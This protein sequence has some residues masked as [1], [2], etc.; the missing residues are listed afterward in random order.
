MEEGTLDDAGCKP[1]GAGTGTDPYRIET[2]EAFAWFALEHPQAHAVLVADIDLTAQSGTEA[3]RPADTAWPGD[4]VLSGTLDGDGH[5]LLFA[6]EGA[7]LFAQVA[8]TGTAKWLVLGRTD[9]Q[10]REA[11][12][13][14][15]RETLVASKQTLAGSVAGANEGT[16]RGIVNLMAVGI[17]GGEGAAAGEALAGGIVALND[18]RIIDCANLGAV[19]NA[20]T[21]GSSAAAGIA[22]A[23]AGSV[24]A[25]YNAA[26]VNA[27]QNGAPLTAST[28]LDAA[29]CYAADGE[30]SEHGALSMSEL[31]GAA[32]RLNAG[33]ADA[34]AVW[35]AGGDATRGLPVPA[36]SAAARAGEPDAS[37]QSQ[38][39]DTTPSGAPEANLVSKTVE[40]DP[41]DENGQVVQRKEIAAW[42]V[43]DQDAYEYSIYVTDAL[44]GS[45][46]ELTLASTDP[47]ANMTAE[48]AAEA[49]LPKQLL[50]ALNEETPEETPAANEGESE[51]AP[52]EA[53]DPVADDA[54]SESADA[55]ANEST[56]I[57]TARPNAADAAAPALTETVDVTWTSDDYDQA[58]V[59]SSGAT[60]TAQ[61]STGYQLAEGAIPLSIRI[62]AGEASTLATSYYSWYSVGEVIANAAN[63]AGYDRSSDVTVTIDKTT[64][65]TNSVVV[66]A[67]NESAGGFVIETPEQLAWFA[68]KTGDDPG[69]Y[70]ALNVTIKA[71]S[72]IDLAGTDYGGAVGTGP[73]G[74]FDEAD[75]KYNRALRWSLIGG[76]DSDPYKGTFTAYGAKITNLYV[77]YGSMQS[78]LFGWVDGA[79]IAGV[80]VAGGLVDD[81][82]AGGIVWSA[83][84]STLKDCRNAATVHSAGGFAGGI[85]GEVTGTSTIT[86]CSNEG[87]VESSFAAGGIVG[88]V[89]RMGASEIS[90][91]Y[92]SGTIGGSPE[93]GGG[94]YG[95]L[96]ANTG[97]SVKGCLSVGS[98]GG[99]GA[100]RAFGKNEGNVAISNSYCLDTSETDVAAAKKT[101]AQL[102][103]WGAA[104]A[105]NDGATG[106]D[107]ADPGNVAGMDAW[108][109][110]GANLP[111]LIARD[112]DG[113][114]TAAMP[115]AADWSD[116]G[117]WV[118]S[119][120]PTDAAGAK[121][122]P[123][124]VNDQFK[125]SSPEGLAWFSID[126]PKASS[127]INAG[128]D[129]DA[130]EIDLAGTKYGGSLADSADDAVK[131]ANALTWV[132][133]DATQTIAF[134]G[135]HVPVKNLHVD[136][137]ENAGLFGKIE[138]SSSSDFFGVDIASG[139]V[140]GT[141]TAAGLVGNL[142]AA[143]VLTCSNKATIEGAVSAGGLVGASNGWLHA[144]SSYNTGSIESPAGKA[145]GLDGSIGGEN[146][147]EYCYNAGEVSGHAATGALTATAGGSFVSS[148][149][150]SEKVA[151]SLVDVGASGLTAKA[152]AEF[153]TGEVAW[154]LDAY[155]D[156][157]GNTG[158]TWGQ[159]IVLK[160]DGS[161]DAAAG[162]A[163]PQFR[164]DEGTHPK[165]LK[166]T[167]TYDP[168]FGDVSDAS[169]FPTA[170]Y[171]NKGTSGDKT[172]GV[173]LPQAPAGATWVY[174]LTNASGGTIVSPYAPTLDADF[175]V[176]VEPGIS[177]WEDVGKKQ[178][179]DDL[180]KYHYDGSDWLF[181]PDHVEENSAA[182]E[183]NT[184]EGFI[185][186]KE[187][188]LAWFAYQV[189]QGTPGFAEANVTLRAPC[190]NEY[191]D[192]EGS[193][194]TSV[195]L[196]RGA[197]ETTI[198]EAKAKYEKA[199][200]WVP[201]G[202][203]TNPYKG[204][205][206]AYGLEI[207]TVYVDET[208]SASAGLFGYTDG[209][210]IRGVNLVTGYVESGLDTVS[211]GGAGG[212]V[213]VGTNI[214]MEDCRN[215]AAVFSA[216]TAGGLLGAAQ[217]KA[218][219]TR[220]SNKGLVQS[221][222]YAGGMFGRSDEAA[223]PNTTLYF[224]QNTGSLSGTADSTD[225]GGMYGDDHGA[226]IKNCLSLGGLSNGSLHALGLNSNSSDTVADSYYLDAIGGSG[227]LTDANAERSKTADQLQTWGAAYALNGGATGGTAGDGNVAGMNGW[228]WDGA[229]S[230]PALVMHDATGAAAGTMPKAADWPTVA[231][232]VDNF[233]PTDAAGTKLKP[234]GA[235]TTDDP[236]TISS[237]EGFAWFGVAVP[238]A[239]GD[240]FA[241]IDAST[242][243][244]DLAGL[245]YGGEL[246]DSADDAVKYANALKWVPV[247]SEYA[248]T[249]DG[250]GVPLANLHADERIFSSDGIGM[251]GSSSAGLFSELKDKSV[252]DGI[253]IASGYVNSGSYSAAGLVACSYYGVAAT[254]CSN[255]ATVVG[256]SAGGLVGETEDDP[257]R[258]AA[259]VFVRCSN[260]G[261]IRGQ[262]ASGGIAGVTGQES[263]GT[264]SAVDCY[265]EGELRSSSPGSS[266]G[267][268]AARV[269]NSATFFNCYNVGQTSGGA[270]L[271]V[272]AIGAIGFEGGSLSLA[273]C[274][275]DPAAV[276][277]TPDDAEHGLTAKSTAE[278]MSGEVAWLLD[279][280]GA[281]G[282][283]AA[284]PAVS[285][286]VWGQKVLRNATT[287][288]IEVP[289]P[290]VAY[291][292]DIYP[293]FWH[294]TAG[295]TADGT[296]VEDADHPRVARV[297]V[298]Y[299][300][301]AHDTEY[302]FGN[303]G[304]SLKLPSATS[305]L[306]YEYCINDA[307]GERIDTPWAIGTAGIAEAD[308]A[309]EK[310]DY[311]VAVVMYTELTATLDPND[312][313]ASSATV[314]HATVAR[315][316]NRD[317]TDA[318]A[319]AGAA[320][321][322]LTDTT[323]DGIARAELK[324][325]GDAN[326]PSANFSTW[327]TASAN[328]T[329]S[330]TLGAYD[331]GVADKPALTGSADL[332]A[333]SGTVASL[334]GVALNAA[335]AYN[336]GSERSW[337]TLVKAADNTRYRVLITVKAVTSKTAV[338]DVPVEG[339]DGTFEL[340]PN[341]E[342]KS[343]DAAQS[344][345]VTNLSAF[346]VN[347]S[348]QSVTPLE[349]GTEVGSKKMTEKLVPADAAATLLANENPVTDADQ[350][351]LG[352]KDVSG[353]TLLGSPLYFKAGSPLGTVPLSIALAGNG[354]G[355]GKND[356]EWL[357]FMDYT[358]T[359]LGTDGLF[360]YT[361]QYQ[362]DVAEDD[363]NTAALGKVPATP[364]P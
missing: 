175:T 20:R 157:L 6:T 215:A 181:N 174:R 151:D 166:A 52:E 303:Y 93:N 230:Y 75:A 100:Y 143:S 258:S 57:D 167:V 257:D 13:A 229:G 223:S 39:V 322:G 245:K 276:P 268:I 164:N 342:V 128:F 160:A 87:T 291:A 248:I 176:Y 156:N 207:F 126:A 1:G 36:K 225:V 196:D 354:A 165:V 267:G 363:V 153:A 235:G 161:V 90:F 273:N 316:K 304:S 105:L 103:T 69:I 226:T 337:T 335:A 33:R 15:N 141:G 97:G 78:S 125:I 82:F 169:V 279:T 237:P 280:A 37:P 99:G 224:C 307:D 340:T 252:F 216:A 341:A 19:S 116:V 320:F 45:G 311:T 101:A 250:N 301:I 28:A 158:E 127:S 231:T 312:A 62:P 146:T 318:P 348:V 222:S 83:A 346:P 219:I 329:L 150:D 362:F 244:I 91:C 14:G 89:S 349:V 5:A 272:G 352:V 298:D 172:T 282:S 4:A 293:R 278:F 73:E 289:A 102:R 113:A 292:G 139:Y 275:Y 47:L 63:A 59:A 187:E 142:S 191:V 205:F 358:G 64:G 274:Y 241:S 305:D 199:L 48:E 299:D 85:V 81:D 314:D 251:V 115:A 211:S 254:G 326:G 194:Y 270:N 262:N 133:I 202:T 132:P 297:T 189:N 242:P 234:T 61:L 111:S 182:L 338:V 154:V 317:G 351:K 119:F 331:N 170:A 180:R 271:T 149:Y 324:P 44:D 112:A 246:A 300:G 287:G 26:D 84:N 31:K 162:D 27:A 288:E 32:D 35:S 117:A 232:W 109:W 138:S 145:G 104:Y 265:N 296:Y 9:A 110:D 12:G 249:L 197:P 88:D 236:Y 67:Y 240:I 94:I 16:V 155:T 80:Y 60:F 122:K 190:A 18:G 255:A 135:H 323:A 8:A 54:A 152:T 332:S 74:T 79:T 186:R 364:A 227:T 68:Y 193:A 58:T 53:A 315:L 42:E 355:S 177:S 179:E 124:F 41:V 221:S 213:G 212:L 17:A 22:A 55:P 92:N 192:F 198:P 243:E 183:G 285:R 253:V 96:P 204:T 136:N 228:T 43:P 76:G 353:S 217:T 108:T 114:A 195:G 347:G 214:T 209:A 206:S 50:V 46:R 77:R 269:L 313:A 34:Y 200:R 25:C 247:S 137:I 7:G 66:P 328:G 159:S 266:V 361:A 344:T 168:A 130:V 218:T 264:F 120:D 30:T 263:A 261:T 71:G 359:Y 260:A 23:G 178:T 220:C 129:W 121:F 281:D 357:Y 49:L 147:F 283:A 173:P 336:L 40:T 106:G 239:T 86:R 21:D 238:K 184:A 123:V 333:G 259:S 294:G 10:A 319:I 65:G 56:I 350:V 308:R 345:K 131:Y 107:S 11:V 360:G 343:T 208:T 134:S 284:D 3:P 72:T 339:A 334:S 233:D 302:C 95:Y 256:G 356:V 327:G 201:I 203:E 185:I 290:G 118:E 310:V 188:A 163:Y 325:A 210:T 321:S 148:Y 38:T 171:G 98:M 70:G 140:S 144:Y 309:A 286:S 29:S 51:D 295:T 2:P 306:S 330:L 24:A 277:G